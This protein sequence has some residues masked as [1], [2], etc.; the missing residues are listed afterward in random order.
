M[1]NKIQKPRGTM[2]IFPREAL[3]WQKIENEARR[4]AKLYGFGEVRTPTFE[5]LALFKRGVG[6]VTDVVQK[7]MYTFADRDE[8]RSITL[9]PE[10]TAGVVRALIENG[11]HAD[12]MP[13]KF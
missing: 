13:Q 2:D 10:G 11:K 5:E 8:E 9:R 3:L 6:E 4:V 7:E 12:T 1:A